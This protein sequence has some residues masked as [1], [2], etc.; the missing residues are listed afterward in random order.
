M[1][2]K[3]A[4]KEMRRYPSAIVG[5]FFL[6]VFVLFSIIILFVL[7]HEEAVILWRAGPGVF[8]ENP[9]RAPPAWMDYFSSDSLP[10][11]HVASLEEVGDKSSKPLGDGMKRVEVSLPFEY[12]YDRFPSEISLFT[13]GSFTNRHEDF[14]VHMLRPDG[15]EIT[16]DD[17]LSFSESHSYRISQ[18]PDLRRRLDGLI[19]H[20]GLF[21][22]DPDVEEIEPLKG[23]YE[24]VIQG[25]VPED[26]ELQEARLVVYGQVHGI[27]GTDHLRRD[28]AVGLAWGA[29]VGLMFGVLAAV[30]ANISTFVLGGIGTWFGGKIDSVFQRLTEITMVLP[31]VA[32]LVMI[33]TFYSR[34]IWVILGALILMNIF[35]PMMKTYRAMF[36]QARESPYIEAARAYGAGNFRIIFRYLLPRMA[37]FLIPQFVT[38]IPTFVF[39]EATLAVL[40]LGDPKIPTWGKIIYDARV[41]D[42]L[43]MGDYYWMVLP[44]VLLMLIG[45]SFAMVG[46]TLDRVFNPRLRSI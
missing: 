22:E 45:F 34:S 2:I 10:R 18:D 37:P 26:S 6:T 3:N 17:N 7:P 4:L 27:A 8:D 19:A 36:L 1:K 44:A 13:E 41:N 12:Y 38:V 40:G 32:I 28:L 15:E 29:P 9:R 11:T 35:S 24:L 5:L 42:A 39:L 21:V 30:G 31:N 46:Y 20:R 23:D 16:L 33:G 43:Y 14:S 25:E